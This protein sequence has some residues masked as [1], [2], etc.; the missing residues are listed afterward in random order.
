M[1]ISAIHFR[2]DGERRRSNW[3][4]PAVLL[5]ASCGAGVEVGDP[6]TWTLLAPTDATQSQQLTS[7]T[8]LFTAWVTRAGCSG[9]VT[10]TVFGPQISK[11]DSEIEVIFKVEAIGD[12]LQL[13]PGND[14][15]SI[16]VDLGEPIGDRRIVDGG[17]AVDRHDS[18]T[19]RCREGPVRWAPQAPPFICPETTPSPNEFDLALVPTVPVPA[20]ADG[21]EQFGIDVIDALAP[22]VLG[23][24]AGQVVASLRGFGWVVTVA[25]L[26]I[27]TTT[28]TPD[29]LWNRLVVTICDGLIHDISFD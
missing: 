24:E 6:A 12:G 15:V 26:P 7:D 18:S 9:G 20:P 10:G 14:T 21:R 27:T 19:G 28:T 8:E 25:E 29:L 23:R 17:C 1:R 4:V 22:M 11:G 13:C 3:A 2:R 16:E 5:L